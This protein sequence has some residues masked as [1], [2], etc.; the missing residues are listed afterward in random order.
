M[1]HISFSRGLQSEYNVEVNIA[2]GFVCYSE[3]WHTIFLPWTPDKRG[4]IKELLKSNEI[5][6]YLKADF[7]AVLSL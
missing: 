2:K 3:W 4:C 7:T 5:K 6:Y 1:Q